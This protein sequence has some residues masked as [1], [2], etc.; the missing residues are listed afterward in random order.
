MLVVAKDLVL[1]AVVE[2]RQRCAVLDNR[3]DRISAALDIRLAPA[4]FPRETLLKGRP[5]RMVSPVKA[6]SSRERRSVAASRML[7]AIGISL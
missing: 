2:D 1:A 4:S 7:S 5:D 6:A 3:V